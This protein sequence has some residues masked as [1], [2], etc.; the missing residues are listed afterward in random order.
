MLPAGAGA[1][2]DAAGAPPNPNDGALAAVVAG[3]T[4]AVFGATVPIVGAGAAALPKEKPE[5][6]V[7]PVAGGPPNEK[8]VAAGAAA[9]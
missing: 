4:A 1:A 7:A 3:A 9:D 8:L 5:D 2:T 6:P